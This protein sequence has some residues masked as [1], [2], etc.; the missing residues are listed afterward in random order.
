MTGAAEAAANGKRIRASITNIFSL[1]AIMFIMAVAASG[2]FGQATVSQYFQGFETDG[3]WA[4]TQTVSRVSSG[5]NGIASKTGGF[6][7]EVTTQN[8][9]WGGYSSVF[10]EPGYT[11]AVSIYL[12]VGG[13]FANDTRFDWTSAIN[14]PDGTHRRDFA[15]NAGFYNDAVL[16]GIGPRFVISP[17]NGTGRGNSNPK[18]PARDPFVITASGWYTFQHKFFDNGAGQLLVEL[19]ILD[20]AG[21]PVHT[22]STSFVSDPTDIIGSTVG[23]NRYGWFANNE[24]TFLAIDDS[25]RSNIIEIFVDDDGMADGTGCDGTTPTFNTIQGAVNASVAGETISVCPGTYAENVTLNKSLTLNGAQAGVDARGRVAAESIISPTTTGIT[26]SVGVA[27]AV[28]NGFTI[29]GGI[30]GIDSAGGPLNGLQV[31]NNRVIGFTGNGIFLND[32]GIDITFNQ[33]VIDGASKTGSG[34]LMHLDTDSF[35]GF[36]FTNNNITGKGAADGST[37]FFVDGNLNVGVSATP[38]TPLF[39]GNLITACNT[40]TNLGSR[41]F[42][43]GTISG[44]TWS[45][46]NFDG[47]QGGIQSTTI[48]GNTFSGNGRS[49]LALTSF[50]NTIDPVRGAKNTIVVGNTMSGNGFTQANGAGLSFGVQF[51]G[52]IITNQAR[53][54][55]IVGNNIGAFYNGTESPINAENNWW[56]CN[57][58]P[59]GAATGGCAAMPNGT[60]GAGD[61]KSVV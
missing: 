28:I 20:A 57:T 14:K 45:N 39:S 60:G 27:G 54:N 53:F 61:R 41:A 7:G 44:N 13:A 58:G 22:W 46:N 3:V 23:G 26:L 15:F 50:G 5:S 4:S 21:T 31:L 49:G 37:G 1:T 43:G 10:P 12:N 33:N 18:N 55:R 19:S 38:R 25:E 42:T 9:Q 2:V 16:P 48:S 8:T 56:G 30:R 17:S 51:P 59:G 47:L 35:A 36:H 6:H 40:G 11:T 24:F 29:S 32:S 34:G 52:T